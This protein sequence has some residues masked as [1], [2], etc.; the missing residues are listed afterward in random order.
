MYKICHICGAVIWDGGIEGAYYDDNHHV[1]CYQ[2][3]KKIKKKPFEL[4]SN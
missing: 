3:F 1:L 4:P 2:C